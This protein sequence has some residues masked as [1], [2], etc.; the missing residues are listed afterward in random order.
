MINLVTRPDL[1]AGG[2]LKKYVLIGLLGL[3]V[4]SAC[5]SQEKIAL[6]IDES[7]SLGL[8]KNRS[9]H[10]SSLRVE[11]ARARQSQADA[12]LLPSVR[13]GG[14]YTRLSEV[15]P[16]TLGPFPPALN[17]PVTISPTV[18]D[19]YAVRLTIQQPIFS[20]FRLS[21]LADVAEFS[22]EAL[23]EE[24]ERDKADLELA[25]RT[26]YWNLFKA[27]TLRRLL[28]ENIAQMD[29]HLRDAKH[30]MDQGMATRN[31]YLKVEVQ[32]STTML[33]QLDAS[34]HIQLAML[35]LNTL[36]GVP[37]GTE[38]ELTSIPDS[39][40][41]SLKGEDVT[42]LVN[43]A[44][45]RRHELR[46][47]HHRIRANESSV[48]AAKAGWFPQFSL[49][50]N[51]LYARPNPRWF[52]VEDRYHD[53]WDVGVVASW[54]VWNW[55]L[56]SHQTSEMNL[57]LSQTLDAESQ[58]RD[59]ITFEVRQSYLALTLADE[60][61]KLSLQSV[62]QADENLRVTGEKYRLGLAL[63]SDLL[64]AESALLLAK[65]NHSNALVEKTLAAAR[66]RKS[67]GDSPGR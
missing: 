37:I 67:V 58:L 48:R 38:I 66:L 39:V 52:P 62:S 43:L 35:S 28:Y 47:V 18:R 42:S 5:K 51:Y 53:T 19:N 45:E 17:T 8:S 60:R 40:D 30:L 31:D 34:Q 14:S 24:Y 3:L 21:S 16:F 59:A 10:S 13:L 2:M 15:P 33:A 46:A 27:I 64:D 55:G 4:S 29:A 25:I 61:V 6:S 57:Q 20:G 54:D 9:L 50:A 63:N 12:A 26:A 36:L 32:R 49:I 1:H 23:Q 56:T 65:T 7:V 11:G 41:D 44:L 22:T